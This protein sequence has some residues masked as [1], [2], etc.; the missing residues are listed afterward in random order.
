MTRLRRSVAV[1]ITFVLLSG[2]GLTALIATRASMSGHDTFQI[3]ALAAGTAA[4]AGAAG[5]AALGALRTRSLAAQTAGLT[6][7][8]VVSLGL[9]VWIG[10]AFMFISERDLSELAMMLSAAGS[11]AVATA[12]VLGRRVANATTSLVEA[13]RRLG[14]GQPPGPT[15][16]VPAEFERLARELDEAAARLADARRREAA[17]EQSRRELVAWVSHDLR[18]PL[19]GIRAIAEALEDGIVSDGPTIAAYH[20]TLRTEAERLS[21]LVDDLFELS[22]TQ[23]GVIRLHM[24]RVS[25]ADLISDALAGVAPVAEA[26]GVQLVGRVEE[27]PP[28]VSVSPPEVVRALRNILENAVRHTPSDGTV[29]VEA[30]TEADRAYVSVVDDGGGIPESDLERVFDV[31]FRGDQART[32]GQGGAG[33][34]LAIARDLVAAHHGDISVRNENGGCRFTVRLPI[35]S[36]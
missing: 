25:W 19:A 22:R 30:G 15:R 32:P 24:Q 16:S 26:K 29:L 12:L 21:E 9:G 2:A 10:A 31:A 13:A 11:V 6:L 7:V 3:V 36:A 14:D 5:A 28:V 17:L 35:R 23:A 20:S 4:I 33:L 18:T 27:A 1:P 34:G 8:V